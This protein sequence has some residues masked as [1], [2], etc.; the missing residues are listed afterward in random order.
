MNFSDIIPY[1]DKAK[2]SPNSEHLA[3]VK[4]TR[5]SI[6]ESSR[7][8]LLTSHSILD[9]VSDL[10]WSQ[11][12]SLLLVCQSKRGLVQVINPKDPKFECKISM[13]PSGLS[14][15]Y[16]SPDG[17]HIITICKYKIRANIWSL[18][19]KEV[20]ALQ[21]PKFS[22]KGV[23]FSKCGQFTGVLLTSLGR[24]HMQIFNKSFQ[25]IQKF[26]LKTQNTEEVQWSND[27]FY[28]L[29]YDSE[30]FTVYE[31]NGN[32]VFELTPG[33][34][35][36]TG[37]SYGR[38]GCY[39]ALNL[40]CNKVWVLHSTTWNKLMEVGMPEEG[41]KEIN[42]Y[43]EE[44]AFKDGLVSSSYEVVESFKLNRIVDERN[45]GFVRWSYDE[46]Y[47][48]VKFGMSYLDAIP[49]VIYIWDMITLALK[50]VLIHA[51]SVKCIEWCKI[52][53]VCV[54]GTSNGRIYIWSGDGALLCDLP[55]GKNNIDKEFKV[56]GLDWSEDGQYFLVKN[57][58][59]LVVAYPNLD[60]IC[61]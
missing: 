4:G 40:S 60:E 35:I 57:K 29:A 16:L 36:F 45:V 48:A 26:Q 39:L 47:V 7:L 1:S 55:F 41:G 44:E 28:I 33:T 53:N 51:K 17:S 15:C 56:E 11:D 37:L 20:F 31:P 22:H 24:D 2:F 13:G 52:K 21:S 43:Q 61:Q 23:I 27:N 58:M 12:S 30:L 50:S 34:K 42:V 3:I 49:N 6:Y 25:S 5:L 32:L 59:E 54:I 8:S 9:H 46:R 14:G 38:N 10:S 18:Q 19:Q